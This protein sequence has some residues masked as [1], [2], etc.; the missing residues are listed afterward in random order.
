M[1]DGDNVH[2]EPLKKS[3]HSKNDND[4]NH[5]WSSSGRDGACGPAALS[6]VTRCNSD[7]RDDENNHDD[8]D[9]HD[10]H[11]GYDFTR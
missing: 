3:L 7:D 5:R 6:P 8:H 11:D 1:I 2:N 9:N 10:N 4:D